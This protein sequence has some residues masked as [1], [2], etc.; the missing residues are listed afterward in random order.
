MLAPLCS[1]DHDGINRVTFDTLHT[2]SVTSAR[3]VKSH[4]HKRLRNAGIVHFTGIRFD[5]RTSA[6]VVTIRLDTSR[7]NAMSFHLLN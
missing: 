7:R 4:G 1:A 2:S 5:K 3:P 6:V